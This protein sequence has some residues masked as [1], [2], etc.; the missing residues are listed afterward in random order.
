MPYQVPAR[1]RDG[2]SA[3][4]RPMEPG[5]SAPLLEVFDQMSAQARTLRYFTGLTRLPGPM[6]RALTEVDG[7]RHLAWTALVEGRHVGLARAVRLPA[8]PGTAEIAFEVADAQQGRGLAGVL[9]DAVT[10]AASAR[11]VRR[12][13]A[14][15]AAENAASRRLL[16]R[17]GLHGHLADGLLELSGPLRLFDPALVDRAAVVR[18]TCLAP[19]TE[20]LD[21]G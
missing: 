9:V 10:T 4:L 16:S 13:V 18:S 11:G 20:A 1:L 3:T 19:A 2:G 5:E 17:L 8:S 21:I 15:V 14:T 7:D 6:L 12:L